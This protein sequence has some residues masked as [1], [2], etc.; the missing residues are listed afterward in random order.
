MPDR[1][2]E[3]R[4]LVPRTVD[5]TFAFFAD[6]HNLEGIT[7]PWLRFGILEAPAELRRGALLR[8]RLRLFGVPI[9][10]RTEITAWSPPHTFTDTQLRGPYRVWVHTHRF[11]PTPAGTE[12]YDHV[13]YCVPGGPAAPL[14]ERLL[15][16]R[17]LAAIFDYRASR[18]AELLG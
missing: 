2:L 3:R 9:G 11:T 1:E 14:A 16:R 18:L 8:Y 10:W 7:P 5:E 13:R 17:W 6:P 4:Q 15:V 12:I